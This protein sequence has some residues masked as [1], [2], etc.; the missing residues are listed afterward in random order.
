ML[1]EKIKEYLEDNADKVLSQ[2]QKDYKKKLLDLGFNEKTNSSFIEFMS[3]YS[4]EYYG[5][6]GTLIDFML[7]IKQFEK[8]ETMILREHDKI[9]SNFFSLLISESDDYL[10]Y[11][12]ENDS[13][14]LVEA[15]N[16][17]QLSNDD[18]FDQKWDSFNEF[19][20]HFFELN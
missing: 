19:L 16:M 13:V 12:K 7:D 4:D 8:S 11:N 6:E 1:T 17:K 10:L 3:I 9:N 5:V 15:E 18:Y 20:E 14:K 2:Y